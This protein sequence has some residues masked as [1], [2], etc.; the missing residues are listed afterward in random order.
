MVSRLPIRTTVSSPDCRYCLVGAPTPAG[1]P[2][3][4]TSPACRV[5]ARAEGDE[6]GNRE[7]RLLVCAIPTPLSTFLEPHIEILAILHFAGCYQMT[8]RQRPSPRTFPPAGRR[9]RLPALAAPIC[10]TQMPSP[11]GAGGD[12]GAHRLDGHQIQSLSGRGVCVLLARGLPPVP[13]SNRPGC[14]PRQVQSRPGTAGNAVMNIRCASR[15]LSA[16]GHR[17][18]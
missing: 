9:T 17:L 8:P 4:I 2:A 5:A 6:V 13:P 10:L 14:S 16:F 3:K 11:A 1:V 15:A 12:I 18:P 7:G